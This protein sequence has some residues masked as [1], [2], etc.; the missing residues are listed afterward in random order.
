[1]TFMEVIEKLRD[2]QGYKFGHANLSGFFY[3][4]PFPSDDR[5]TKLDGAHSAITFWH[6]ANKRGSPTLMLYDFDDDTNW[7]CR[8][9]THPEL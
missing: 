8:P 4:A 1:M 7:Y 5:I 3:K 9:A 6:H 2:G